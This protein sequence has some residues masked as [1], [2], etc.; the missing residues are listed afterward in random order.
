MH[1]LMT[2]RRISMISAATRRINNIFLNHP[3]YLLMSTTYDRFAVE[4]D[5]ITF[6]SSSSS[7]LSNLLPFH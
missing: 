6:P 7:S 5:G 1:L 4:F 2:L 3:N